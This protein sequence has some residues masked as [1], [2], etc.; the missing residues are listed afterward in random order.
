M[1]KLHFTL[2][3]VCPRCKSEIIHRVLDT[4]PTRYRCEKCNFY[5]YNPD[6]CDED[7][8]YWIRKKEQSHDS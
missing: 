1:D 8:K 6:Y 4:G 5:F 2:T 7:F 3:A